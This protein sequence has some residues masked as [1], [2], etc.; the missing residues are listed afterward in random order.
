MSSSVK[1]EFLVTNQYTLKGAGGEL[2]NKLIRHAHKDKTPWCHEHHG[3]CKRRLLDI[4][5]ASKG[6]EGDK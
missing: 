5:P 4:T 1:V 3:N 2:A 6:E